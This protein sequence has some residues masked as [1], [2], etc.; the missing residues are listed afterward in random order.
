[1]KPATERRR[2]ERVRAPRDLELRLVGNADVLRIRDVSSSGVCCTTAQPFPVMSKVHLIL[3][4]PDGRG[5]NVEVPSHGVVVRCERSAD[6][7]PADGRS[8]HAESAHEIAVFFTEIDDR[9]REA[10][11]DFV[12][13]VHRSGQV[14]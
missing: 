10:L 7:R 13:R 4:L 11:S 1:M 2:A 8:A 9:D 3:V 5:G 12:Q 6:A 14:A